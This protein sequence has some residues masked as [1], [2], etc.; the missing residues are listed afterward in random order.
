MGTEA[1]GVVV[2][3]EEFW[4]GLELE[5]VDDE[6]LEDVLEE[7]LPGL[8]EGYVTEDELLVVGL[9]AVPE[10]LELE[11]DEEDE[12]CENSEEDSS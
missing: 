9:L 4:V 11:E 2:E 3:P 7:E 1:G 6:A 10:L 12:D 8:D 5:E